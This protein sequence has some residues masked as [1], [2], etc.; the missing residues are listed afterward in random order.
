MHLDTLPNAYNMGKIIH[1]L[2]EF[3]M[4]WQPASVYSSL[5]SRYKTPTDNRKNA[6]CVPIPSVSLMLRSIL[7]ASL[8]NEI[9]LNIS[10][11]KII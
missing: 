10:Y 3:N 1:S 11:N 7:I 9:M 2:S 5:L 6:K 8:N 4:Y